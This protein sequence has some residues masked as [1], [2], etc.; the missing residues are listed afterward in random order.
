VDERAAAPDGPSRARDWSG[1]VILAVLS[2]LEVGIL[3][4]LIAVETPAAPVV[5]RAIEHPIGLVTVVL[6]V[7]AVLIVAM[8]GFTSWAEWYHG[9]RGD[10][11]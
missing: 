1:L 10:G 5:R 11:P 8:W 4:V 6:F 7:L 2:A 9:Q 3:W